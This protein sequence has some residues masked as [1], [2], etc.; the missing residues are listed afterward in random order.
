MP[1]LLVVDREDSFLP[2]GWVSAVL[3]DGTRPSDY[4]KN[5][6]LWRP[7]PVPDVPPPSPRKRM[8]EQGKRLHIMG[9]TLKR[10]D[11]CDV[12]LNLKGKPIPGPES[13]DRSHSTV[14]D[15]GHNRTYSHPQ[16]AYD[17]LLA[18][19]GGTVFTEI[20]YIRGWTG[21]YADAGSGWVLNMS[22]AVNPLTEFKLICDVEDGETV[23]FATPTSG[24]YDA[25]VNNVIWDGIKVTQTGAAFDEKA[26]HLGEVIAWLKNI[27][28]TGDVQLGFLLVGGNDAR[29]IM[30]DSTFLTDPALSYPVVTNHDGASSVHGGH[31]SFIGNRFYAKGD[32]GGDNNAAVHG[33]GGSRA[34]TVVNNTLKS[35]QCSALMIGNQSGNHSA[36]LILLNNI[37]QTGGAD[38][39]CL[40]YS[41]SPS[42]RQNPIIMSDGNCYHP[43][44][45]GRIVRIYD[46][47]Q[48]T[49][50]LDKWRTV[51]EGDQNSIEADPLLDSG[52]KPQAGSPCLAGGL[53]MDANGLDG[54]KR[55]KTIDIGAHQST[56]AGMV[57]GVTPRRAPEIARRT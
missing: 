19:Q 52:L 7:V 17:A 44:T 23:T 10:L 34:F 3:P 9:G 11:V 57:A 55:A 48:E 50:D 13:L 24:V 43:A 32:D 39:W 21:T 49:W 33:F 47:G 1:T 28:V 26:F 35:G 6:R 25:D 12:P 46:A 51:T 36:S 20:H 8:G 30:T 54:G 27:E 18:W 5:G 45:A 38:Q 56:P 16:A 37:L 29:I 31:F 42:A 53:C 22:P 2:K 14:W 41:L 4:E 15:Y 40:H